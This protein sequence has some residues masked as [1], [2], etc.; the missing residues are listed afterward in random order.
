MIVHENHEAVVGKQ[1]HVPHESHVDRRAVGHAQVA[2]AAR[3]SVYITNLSV[4]ISILF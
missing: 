4:Y 1:A 3:L 2:G